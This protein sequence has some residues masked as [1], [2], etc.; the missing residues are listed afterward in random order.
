MHLS[1]SSA[2]ES[3]LFQRKRVL[4]HKVAVLIT[5]LTGQEAIDYLRLPLVSEVTTAAKRNH[6]SFG[7]VGIL[8]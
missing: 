2:R 8:Y 1:V 7:V 6:T 3:H 5:K 4:T